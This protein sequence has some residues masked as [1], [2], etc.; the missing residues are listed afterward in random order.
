MTQS[1]DESGATAASPL[2]AALPLELPVPP[3]VHD[4]VMALIEREQAALSRLRQA[5]TEAGS[6]RSRRRRRWGWTAALAG[7]AAAGVAGIMGSA[8]LGTSTQRQETQSTLAG[9]PAAAEADLVAGDA[10]VGQVM[11]TQQAYARA[12][13]LL[14]AL[15]AL[16]APGST[17]TD[18]DPGCLAQLS[19]LPADRGQD[20]VLAQSIV[21]QGQPALLVA[22]GQPAGPWNIWVV[23]PKCSSTDPKVLQLIKAPANSA[24]G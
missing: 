2:A 15:P 8:L 5:G 3:A 17:I 12:G 13:E 18:V 19:Q 4:Q 7:L 24:G 6:Q 9:A 11:P 22:L 1:Q 14:L 23:D 16:L 10:T 20:T 21:F